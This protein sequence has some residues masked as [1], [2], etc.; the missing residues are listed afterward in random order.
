M[1]SQN[2]KGFLWQRRHSTRSIRCWFCDRNF[3]ISP[4]DTMEP[5]YQTP[6]ELHTLQDDLSSPSIDAFSPEKSSYT[7]RQFPHA[8]IPSS[9][10]SRSSKR[11]KYS[12]ISDLSP[13][14]KFS[15][16]CIL[17]PHSWQ[18]QPKVFFAHLPAS[19]RTAITTMSTIINASTSRFLLFSDYRALRRPTGF[20]HWRIIPGQALPIP[21]LTIYS[22]RLR[23]LCT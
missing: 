11:L 13:S 2:P 14:D 12:R 23:T 10:G 8:N 18:Q 19:T 4:G 15:N 6:A 9:S 3:A 22:I 1:Q 20:R 16:G 5:I 21:I 7:I 17:E